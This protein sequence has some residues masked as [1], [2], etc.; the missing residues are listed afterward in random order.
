M[1]KYCILSNMSRTVLS[2]T[3][4]C[5]KVFLNRK[6]FFENKIKQEKLNKQLD[7]G[8]QQTDLSFWI[9]PKK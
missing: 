2:K 1:D 9:T 8:K 5:Y 4:N 6:T 3:S 7:E